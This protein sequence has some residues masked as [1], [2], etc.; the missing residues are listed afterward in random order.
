M[1]CD[2]CDLVYL[3][4]TSISVFQV[5]NISKFLFVCVCVCCVCVY[6]YVYTYIKQNIVYSCIMTASHYVIKPPS[7]ALTF[8]NYQA[9][10]YFH[11]LLRKGTFSKILLNIKL[12][13]CFG[14]HYNLSPNIYCQTN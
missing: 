7:I 4:Q 3:N 1:K 14:I 11:T 13:P 8:V 5:D 2:F 6:E 9:M 10:P 12:N